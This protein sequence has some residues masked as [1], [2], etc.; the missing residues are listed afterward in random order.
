[1]D[2]IIR[3]TLERK[4]RIIRNE[5]EQLKRDLES[6]AELHQQICKEINSYVADRERSKALLDGQCIGWGSYAQERVQ[7][8]E[9]EIANLMKE[10][11]LEQVGY[12][13]NCIKL[14]N[15]L[16]ELLKEYE[17]LKK[18]KEFLE[19]QLGVNGNES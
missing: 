2:K 11:R 1:M 12:W 17:E 7:L 18:R 13:R 10:K 19:E 16:R 3:E 14:K 4:I 5:I 9:R 15:E 8:I 6:R